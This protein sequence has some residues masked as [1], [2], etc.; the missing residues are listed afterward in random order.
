V[1]AAVARAA[2]LSYARVKRA[3]GS[4]KGEL[5]LD[6]AAWLLRE[7]GL[8]FRVSRP[9]NEV[10]AQE[11]AAKQSRGRAVLFL[12]GLFDAHAVSCVNGVVYDPCDGSD[13][14]LW[15]VDA[16]FLLT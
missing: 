12:R 16:A 15:P 11:W 9:R 2:G 14:H 3:C 4:T 10:K 8:A 1:V 5:R 13:S 6:E 7:L